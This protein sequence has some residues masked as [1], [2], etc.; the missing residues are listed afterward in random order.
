MQFEDGGQ[1]SKIVLPGDISAVR[2][3]GSAFNATRE[4]VSTIF[5]ELGLNVGPN[6]VRIFQQGE[7]STADVQVEDPSCAESLC[8]KLK[9]SKKYPEL[10][11]LP[12]AFSTLSQSTSR[13]INCRKVQIS[14]Y[15]PTR[16]F[17]LNFGSGEVAARVNRKFNEGIYT[18]L[19][20]KIHADPPK[21]STSRGHFG[22]PSHNPVA[23]TVMLTDLPY[24]AVVMDVQSSIR[25]SYDKPR[26]IEQGKSLFHRAPEDEPRKIESLLGKIGPVQFVMNAESQGKR[27]K[28]TALFEEEGDARE[29]VKALHGEPQRFLDDGKLTVTLVNSAKFKVFTTVYDVLAK[30]LTEYAEDFIIKHLHFKVYRNTDPLQKFTILKVE[31]ESSKEIASAA[32]KI[33]SLLAGEVVQAGDSPIWTPAFASKGDSHQKLQQI[34][35]KHDVLLFRNKLKRQLTFFGS[36]ENYESVLQDLQ[37]LVRTESS[38]AHTIQLAPAE[39]ALAC[40]GGF[41]QITAALGDNIAS[42]D[43]VSRPRKIV[44]TG[45]REQYQKALEIIHGK[46]DETRLADSNDTTK[47]CTVCW[48]TA[49]NSLATKC[50]HVYCADCFEDMCMAAASSDQESTI[51]CQGNMGKCDGMLSLREIQDHLS[52]TSF[53]QLLEALFNSCISHQPQKFRYCPTPDCGSIYRVSAEPARNTCNKCLEVV[54]TSCHNQHGVITCAEYKDL[55]S[56]GYSAFVAYKKEKGIK[57]CPECTTPMEKTDGCNHMVCGGCKAHVC[58]VCLRT[59]PQSAQC[60]EHMT[61]I[62]GGIGID[63]FPDLV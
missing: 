2:I 46:I 55:S 25:M 8:A 15:K 33:E 3:K 53:E 42:F 39:F 34:E 9:E 63:Y 28:A 14:W 31:G 22:I 59:F 60:Y 36:S 1:I 43:I 4:T 58:W 54:C 35:R 17:W 23:W 29:A 21:H 16:T 11:V 57:D 44:V 20:S 26:H 62:H 7:V 6:A 27:F 5:Q 47:D 41:R 10:E 12:V 24:K 52:T 51:R 19:G 45:S 49:E 48:T 18:V 37:D 38:K 56:G 40:N 61:A 32:N 13:R 50:D 30:Q